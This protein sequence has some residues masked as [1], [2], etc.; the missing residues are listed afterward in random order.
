M[1]MHEELT[2]YSSVGAGLSSAQGCLRVFNKDVSL[3]GTS[4]KYD[5]GD[6]SS[7]GLACQ[8]QSSR[9]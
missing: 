6:L 5:M 4:V 1:G 3:Q 7:Q 8:E 2:K 9:Y